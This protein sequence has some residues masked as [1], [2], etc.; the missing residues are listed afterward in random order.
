MNMCIHGGVSNP[1]AVKPLNM[2]SAFILFYTIFQS[3]NRMT[4]LA[5]AKTA[6]NAKQSVITN[7]TSPANSPTNDGL[8]ELLNTD[9]D[10]EESNKWGSLAQRE[11]ITFLENNLE[12]LT[13]MQ[14]TLLHDNS[15]LRCEIP[16]LEKRYKVR[17]LR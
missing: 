2:P 5:S 6:G 11:K 8:K 3:A 4:P 13:K 9:T 7:T 16:K 10:D 12:K 15:E 17:V 1:K 14:K